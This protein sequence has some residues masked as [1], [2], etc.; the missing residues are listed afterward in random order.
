[1]ATLL[2]RTCG[3]RFDYSEQRVRLGRD[4]IEN[5]R[6]LAAKLDA[7][8]LR[9]EDSLACA[10]IEQTVVHHD[11]RILPMAVSRV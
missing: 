1:M 8:T 10:R 7:G 4:M 6:V 2:C 3:A 5:C 9:R 11:S